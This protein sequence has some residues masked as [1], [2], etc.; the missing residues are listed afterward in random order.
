MILGTL[1]SPLTPL[2]SYGVHTNVLI[3]AN[4]AKVGC[5]MPQA[6]APSAIFGA[7]GLTSITH[8]S[9]SKQTALKKGGNRIKVSLFKGDL[10]GYKT[11]ETD[12][13]TFQTSS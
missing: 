9:R 11:F 12:K 7:L 1:R 5:V 2:K 3:T 13:R 6:H 10:E 8:P 4:P